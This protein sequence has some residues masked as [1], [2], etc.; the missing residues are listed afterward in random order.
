MGLWG[1]VHGVGSAE[2]QFDNLGREKRAS[3]MKEEAKITIF[4]VLIENFL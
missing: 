3:F 4:D 1:V 2:M